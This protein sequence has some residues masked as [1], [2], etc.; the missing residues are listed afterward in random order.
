MAVG[1]SQVLQVNAV[2]VTVTVFVF[3]ADIRDHEAA[4]D[5]RD[6]MLLADSLLQPGILHRVELRALPKIPVD[7]PFHLVI[8][9]DSFD[10]AASILDLLRRGL[11]DPIKRCVVVELSDLLQS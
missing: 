8:E 3:E 4:I 5:Q 1:F 10:F 11:I 2:F 9:D 7:F 6:F